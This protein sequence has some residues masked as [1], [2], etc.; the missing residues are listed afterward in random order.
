MVK[1]RGL[2]RALG[3]VVARGLGR[4][5]DGDDT[6]DLPAVP[7][8]EAAVAGDEPMVDA[9]T[10]DTSAEI[11]AQDT[12]AQDIGDEPEGFPS[13]PRD[14]S[15]LTEYVDHVAASVWSGQECPELKLSS[16]GRKVHNL[17]RPVPTIEDMVA[18][19][20]LSTLIACSIDT[21]DRRLI[22]SFVERWH[23]ETSSFHFLWGRFR[24]R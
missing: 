15:V 2:V 1:T 21:G 13:G 23:R 5:G 22:S 20:G 11:D 7:E 9:A 14:P 24:S 10:Q 18:G 6:D 8:A 16:H 4:G 19:T 12:G 17:G 3:R